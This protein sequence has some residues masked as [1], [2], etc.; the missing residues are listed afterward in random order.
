MTTIHLGAFADV[1]ADFILIKLL[2]GRYRRK[3]ATLWNGTRAGEVP[4]LPIE[5]A[6]AHA[7]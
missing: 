6:K 7:R 1:A 3:P 4:S 5:A 2:A